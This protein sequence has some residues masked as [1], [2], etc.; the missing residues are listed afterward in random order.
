MADV[1][2]AEN[3]LFTFGMFAILMVAFGQTIPNA[4]V[5][6]NMN[7]LFAGWPT[8]QQTVTALSSPIKNCAS[9]DWSCQA[10]AGVAQA[11]AFVGAAIAYPGVL[12]GSALSR[13]T[14][15]GNLLSFVTFGSATAFGTVPF[16]N[17]FLLALFLVVTILLFK[18][19]RGNPS[20]L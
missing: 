1:I 11:T 17:L 20:G 12:A 19:F 6:N 5:Q 14:S 8:F 2:N 4:D 18:L 15:F 13:V 16:G 10:A 7:T 3:I 9:W